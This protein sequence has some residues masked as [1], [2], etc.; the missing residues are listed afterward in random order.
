MRNHSAIQST[1]NPPHTQRTTD[2][3]PADASVFPAP[4]PPL[5]VAVVVGARSVEDVIE[6]EFAPEVGIS[7]ATDRLAR[8]PDALRPDCCEV[9]V[10]VVTTAAAA[11]RSD[12]VVVVALRRLLLE[13]SPT[14][15]FRGLNRANSGLRVQEVAVGEVDRLPPSRLEACKTK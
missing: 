3:L 15:A 2:A 12:A 14:V 10:E 11:E 1:T 4:P 6:D 13:S 9:T 5:T 8:R 7:P